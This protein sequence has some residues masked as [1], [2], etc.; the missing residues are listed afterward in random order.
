MKQNASARR[1]RRLRDA[2]RRFQAGV[3]PPSASRSPPC[4]P[5]WG[6]DGPSGGAARVPILPCMAMMV[7]PFVPHGDLGLAG[8][9]LPR[10][11]EP[12]RQ[13]L[14]ASARTR[15]LILITV[16]PVGYLGKTPKLRH[17]REDHG[18]TRSFVPFPGKLRPD[19]CLCR[20]DDPGFSLIHGA[21]KTWG[22]IRARERQPRRW[23]WLRS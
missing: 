20:T 16:A 6:G 2:L 12:L 1:A 21:Q 18:S 13:P 19:R 15:R 8:H 10:R 7:E 17:A 9:V 4:E 11:G 14:R 22:R 5:V 3:W 23:I